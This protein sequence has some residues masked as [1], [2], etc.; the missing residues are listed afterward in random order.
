MRLRPAN[1]RGGCR[2]AVEGILI[3]VT[4]W[5]LLGGIPAPV[6]AC[7]D[8]PL[9]AVREPIQAAIRV[10]TDSRYQGAAKRDLQR[11]L[12]RRILEQGFDFREFSRRVL[13]EHWPAFTPDQQKEFERVFSEFLA[14]FYL[15]RLQE[16]YTDQEVFYY[17]QTRLSADRAAVAMAVVWQQ[18]EIPVEVRLISRSGCW[19]TYDVIALGIS[20]VQNYRAQF[21]EILKK[22][23]PAEVIAMVARRLNQN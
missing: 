8:H 14:R 5:I 21:A 4:V 6:A 18:F 15:S 13:A 22:H 23:S 12:L 17:G 3:G 1:A 7:I 2:H 10:L 9:E 16:Y 19:Q 11:L 20:A